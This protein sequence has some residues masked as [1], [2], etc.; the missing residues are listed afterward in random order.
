MANTLVSP[1]FDRLLFQSQHLTVG[2]FR[3]HVAHPRFEDSGPAP[4]HLMVFPRT[5]VAI[6]HEGKAR[7]IADAPVVTLYNSGQRYRRAVISPAGDQCEWF[8]FSATLAAHVMAGM[9]PCY[10]GDPDAP[11]RSSHGPS[12]AISYLAQRRFVQQCLNGETITSL[13]AEEFAVAL[14][15]RVLRTAL[16]VPR[17]QHPPS[18]SAQRDLVDAAKVLLLNH[19]Q[20]EGAVELAARLGCSSF[21]LCR[22]FRRHT[23]QSMHAYREQVRL[24][25]ALEHLEQSP[26]DLTELALT[27]GYHSHSHFSYAFRRAFGIAPSEFRRGKSGLAVAAFREMGQS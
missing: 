12:C 6:Q 27:L 10:A 8:A 15:D 1:D 20:R 7:F 18:Y 22:S 13:Q 19:S 5:A 2:S 23:G 26:S 25:Q 16:A 11:F 3:A 17:V 4:A 21:H 9:D 14:A 24:R